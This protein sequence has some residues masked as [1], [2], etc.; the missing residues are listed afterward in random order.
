MVAPHALVGRLRNLGYHGALGQLVEPLPLY[1]EVQLA[2]DVP[3]LGFRAE[4]VY[5]RV[6]SVREH[7]GQHL[8]GLEF[9]SLSDEASAKIRLFVQMRIQ[10]E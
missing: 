2:F 10:G 5:A 9:T 1:S 4:E 6:V 8:A 7:D 3:R